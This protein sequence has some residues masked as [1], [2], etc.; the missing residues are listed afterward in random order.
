MGCQGQ[1]RRGFWG[2]NSEG[3]LAWRNRRWWVVY[4]GE[5]SAGR[6]ELGWEVGKLGVNGE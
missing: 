4:W 3:F 2:T 6:I 5:G 1:K